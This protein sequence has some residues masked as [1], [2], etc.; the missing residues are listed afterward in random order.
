MIQQ[1][2]LVLLIFIIVLLPKLKNTDDGGVGKAQVEKMALR[3]RLLGED[4][5]PLTTKWEVLKRFKR[6]D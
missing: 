4:I 2:C 3:V 1:F 6:D 5:M